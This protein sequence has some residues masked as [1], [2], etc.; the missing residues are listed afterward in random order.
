MSPNLQ[1]I[2]SKKLARLLRLENDVSVEE[3]FTIQQLKTIRLPERSYTEKIDNI[4]A[5]HPALIYSRPTIS[6]SG[7]YAM[8]KTHRTDFLIASPAIAN[9]VLADA[10]TQYVS[11]SI[12]G[13]KKYGIAY[14]GCSKTPWGKKIIDKVNKVLL[15][16]RSTKPYFRAMSAWLSEDEVNR[17][18]L[19]FYQTKF[20]RN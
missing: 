17:D 14:I 7:L 10:A 4:F 8:L 3:L 15:K 16:I 6:E 1:V 11:L 19:H 12:K 9:Y 5:Q 13:M 2:I 18:Y 20:L